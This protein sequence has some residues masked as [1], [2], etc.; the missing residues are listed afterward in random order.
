V[1]HIQHIAGDMTKF[2]DVFRD[3]APRT[4]NWEVS[5]KVSS[6]DLVGLY[7]GAD[8]CSSGI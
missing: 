8:E 1:E 3:Q 4:F 5:I 7:E 2:M 6:S